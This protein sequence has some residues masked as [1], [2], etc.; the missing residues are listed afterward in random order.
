MRDPFVISSITWHEIPDAIAIDNINLLE[1]ALRDHLKLSDY[2]DIVG[3]AFIYIIEQN[4]DDTHVDSFSYRP[5][6]KEI[7][8]QMSLPYALVQQSNP[9]QVLH[10][11][12]AKYID[13]M[14][15]WLGKKKIPNFDAQR[16]V[17]DVQELFERQDWLQPV[18][19]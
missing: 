4:D 10:L 14:R 15:E 3:I 5:K 18:T 7:Y 17:K 6:R 19:A 1:A 13:T 16:F 11:M 2:G 8:T 9:E 12:A